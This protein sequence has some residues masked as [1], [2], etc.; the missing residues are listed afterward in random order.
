MPRYSDDIFAIIPETL[1]TEYSEAIDI[2]FCKGFSVYATATAIATATENFTD[3]D[4]NVPDSEVTL[5][6]HGYTTGLAV[7]LTTDGTL[8]DPLVVL[9]TYYIIV[10]DANTV[11]F[12]TSYANALA[13]TEIVLID[14]GGVGDAQAVV[15]T[16][17]AGTMTIQKSLDATTW[18]D[19][20]MTE[21]FT[22]TES[23]W[24][25]SAEVWYSYFRLKF[26]V[27]TGRASCSARFN[28]KGN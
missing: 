14:A 25:D 10:V 8:P 4:V 9:T 6:A 12:A 7:T 5:T 28:A 1:A 19:T 3:T 22:A 15:P 24:W 20:T 23:V 18:V 17:L 21:A 11:Q 2:R 16:A 13:G 27:T 26:A